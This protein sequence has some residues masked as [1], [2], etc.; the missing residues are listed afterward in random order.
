MKQKLK[1]KLFFYWW[2]IYNSISLVLKKSYI[3]S[4]N[5][6]LQTQVKLETPLPRKC[7]DMAKVLLDMLVKNLNHDDSIN[8][9]RKWL[10]HITLEVVSGLLIHTNRGPNLS[11][12]LLL[13]WAKI[14]ARNSNIPG[15][16]TGSV[17]KGNPYSTQGNTAQDTLESVPY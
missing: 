17:L 2:D 3:L 1:W 14:Q 9:K 5:K 11:P 13:S 15:D 16:F 7:E 10:F 8:E 6:H 4:R 12:C